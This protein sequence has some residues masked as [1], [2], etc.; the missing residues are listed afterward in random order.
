MKLAAAFCQAVAF[1][2]TCATLGY[3]LVLFL[4]WLVPI[5]HAN[6]TGGVIALA[7]L[8]ILALTWAFYD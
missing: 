5:I 6:P 2:A 4:N 3:S 7:S 1:I 8:F